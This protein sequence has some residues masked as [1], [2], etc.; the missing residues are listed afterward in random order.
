MSRCCDGPKGNEDMGFKEHKSLDTL[1]WALK[2]F[3]PT[4]LGKSTLSFN[5]SYNQ[6]VAIR[7]EAEAIDMAAE[8]DA[9]KF[10]AEMKLDTKMLGTFSYEEVTGLLRTFSN[11][12]GY[13]I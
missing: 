10:N 2:G 3:I 12:M 7:D 1:S 4:K 8:V 13:C 11:A 6:G 9:A 5:F